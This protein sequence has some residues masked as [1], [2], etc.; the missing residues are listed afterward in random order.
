MMGAMGKDWVDDDSM[1]REDLLARFDAL[2]DVEI[3]GPQSGFALGTFSSR[4]T[5][6]VALARPGIEMRRAS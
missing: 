2:P 6:S 1:S 5:D 3:V 4:V